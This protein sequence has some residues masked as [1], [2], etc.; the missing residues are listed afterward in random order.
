MK[1]NIYVYVCKYICIITELVFCTPETNTILQISY[2]L[3][4]FSSSVMFNFFP[5]P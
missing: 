5:T 4:L 1:K 3:L 2:L